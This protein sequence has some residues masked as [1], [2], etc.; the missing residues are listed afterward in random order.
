MINQLKDEYPIRFLCE[1]LDVHRSALYHQPR[2]S[3]DQPVREG[4]IAPMP[5]ISAEFGRSCPGSCPEFPG[6]GPGT[7]ENEATF[8]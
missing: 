7:L 5:R 1:T 4:A 3:E 2:L 8:P 6:E